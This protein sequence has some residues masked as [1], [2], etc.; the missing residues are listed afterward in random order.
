M[1]IQSVA[2]PTVITLAI[3]HS[4]DEIQRGTLVVQRG[5]LAHMRQFPYDDDTDLNTVIRDALVSLTA[6][7]ANPPIISE[8]P[9]PASTPAPNQ[10]VAAAPPG[11][12]TVDIPLKKGKKAVKISHLKI[13]GGETDAAAYRQAVQIASLLINGKLWDGETP[14]CID[15][16]YALADRVKHL[17]AGDMALFSLT[18]FVQIGAVEPDTA[19]QA[20]DDEIAAEV[21]ID[22]PVMTIPQHVVT[23]STNGNSAQTALL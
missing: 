21:E 22:E 23:P 7:E 10:K 14:I 5:E 16:V 6:V 1:S 3:P 12:P 11:E 4:G 20:M 2:L 18:D 15:D 13:V 17:T 19:S 8:A 9:L